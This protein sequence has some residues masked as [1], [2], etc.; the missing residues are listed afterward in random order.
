MDTKTN[1]CATRGRKF[2]AKRVRGCLETKA[3]RKLFGYEDSDEDD[4]G[5]IGQKRDARH[6]PTPKAP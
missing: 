3:R 4:E 5:Y 6:D 1:A 2:P